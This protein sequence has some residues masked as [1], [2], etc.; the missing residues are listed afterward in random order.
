M[1]SHAENNEEKRTIPALPRLAG[2]QRAMAGL[3]AFSFVVMAYV[4]IASNFLRPPRHATPPPTSVQTTD[5]AGH[6]GQ[7]MQ[8]VAK[9]PQNLKLMTHLVEALIQAQNWEAA[10]TFAERASLLDVSDPYP[11]YLQGVIAHNQGKTKE[12]AAFLQK[13]LDLKDAAAARYSLGVLYAY[14][15][16]D[17]AKGRAH[18]AA[19]LAAA[20]LT[21][22]LEKSLREELR[23][24]EGAPPAQAEP[25]AAADASKTPASVPGSPQSGAK[26]PPISPQLAKQI[27]ATEK[28]LLQ[29]PK[30]A[31]LWTHLGNLYFDTGQPV[32]AIAAYERSLSIAPGNPDVLTDLGIM[33]REIRDFQKSLESFD[34]AIAAD[35]G[36]QNALFNKG[37]VLLNDLNRTSDCIAAWQALVKLNPGA[38]APN[39]RPVTELL[40]QLK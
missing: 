37:V 16:D 31:A 21:P 6:I 34:K 27:A 35:P 39:G 32:K 10:A 33:Y 4:A 22:E 36:H 40:R 9:D 15:L 1:S 11:H 7:L 26:T 23:K 12:A 29:K 28:E 19:G 8:Q 18:F 5:D 2:N 20:D 38:L 14:F 25:G 30:S 17:P 3:L 13:S 24:A